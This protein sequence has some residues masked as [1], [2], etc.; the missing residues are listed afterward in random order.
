[1][2][3][4]WSAVP[5]AKIFAPRVI[6]S[7]LELSPVPALPRMTVP[8]SMFKTPFVRTYMKPF[9][10]YVFVRYQL[11]VPERLDVIWIV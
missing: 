6:K 5:L 4:L 7:A 3:G 2:M 8:G 11:F 1:M 10:T 9:R